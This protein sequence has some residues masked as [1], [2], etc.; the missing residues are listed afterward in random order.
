MREVLVEFIRTEGIPVHSACF[1]VAGPVRGGQ[2]KI[3]NLPWTIDCRELAVQ[4]KLSSVGLLN[5]LEAYA[6]GIDA[7]ESK[8]FVTL[9]AGV[10]DAEGNRAVISAKTGLGMAGLYWDGFRHHPFACEG[11]HADFAPKNDRQVELFNYLQKRYGHV[12]CE[13]ILSGPGIRNIYDF[14]RD[15]RKAEE[16]AELREQISAAPDPSA[17]ISQLALQSKAPICEQTMSLFVSILGAEAGNCALRYMTTGGIFIAGIIAA[18][19]LEKMKEAAFLQA[20]FDKG[21]MAALLKDMP[22][23]VIVN[24]DCGLIGSARYTLIKKAFGK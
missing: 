11:G 14:L 10:D 24:D 19:N 17:L 18:K 1:G 21:R 8:D 6:Y 13:R 16:P 9:S 22:V 15:S 7:L 12:S 5:D 3:S 2:S 20:F 4:L 23:K